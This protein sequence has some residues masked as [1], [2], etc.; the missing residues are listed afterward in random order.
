MSCPARPDQAG[1]DVKVVPSVRELLG[2]EVHVGDLREPTEADLLGRRKV[3]TDLQSV[4]DY[5]RGRTVVVTGA[6]GSICSSC[7]VSL[8]AFS[9]A[10]LVMIDR[11]ESGLHGSSCRSRAGPCSTPT[12]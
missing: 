4:S 10:K 3:K 8:S 1:L 2:G 11:D 9:P 5:I 7:A 6:G 12:R